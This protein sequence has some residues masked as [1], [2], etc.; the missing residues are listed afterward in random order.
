[1]NDLFEL[2]ATRFLL[3]PH[4]DAVPTIVDLD[5]AWRFF[6]GVGVGHTHLLTR[7]CSSSAPRRLTSSSARA[8]HTSDKQRPKQKTQRTRPTPRETPE[9]ERAEHR[10]RPPCGTAPRPRRLC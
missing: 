2:G 10:D 3:A 8:R 5:L 9:P 7:R 4:T 6:N 1:M